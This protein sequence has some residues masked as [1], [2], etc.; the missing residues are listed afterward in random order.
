MLRKTVFTGMG[1][2]R[3][4]LHRKPRQTEG[5]GSFQLTQQSGEVEGVKAWF[6]ERSP[7]AYLALEV[8]SSSDKSQR[9]F[10]PPN[11]SATPLLDAMVTV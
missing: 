11:A 4:L 5:A 10:S 1:G 7:R 3:V 2:T 6:V 8:R 9:P